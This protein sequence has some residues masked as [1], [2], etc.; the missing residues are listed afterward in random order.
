M[1]AEGLMQE[2]VGAEVELLEDVNNA[3]KQS[4]MDIPRFSVPLPFSMP[5]DSSDDDCDL[6]ENS[7]SAY[8]MHSMELGGKC[9][10]C[11]V[12]FKSSQELIDHFESHR[13][14]VSTSCNIC[15]GALSC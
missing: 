14:K 9:W 5:D 6:P 3:Y 11:G 10:E 4:P 13:D 15:Q 12:Q 1:A 2:T 8:G 7:V